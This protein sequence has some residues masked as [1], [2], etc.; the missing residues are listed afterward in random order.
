MLERFKDKERCLRLTLSVLSALFLS[1]PWLGLTPSFTL[2]F[3]FVPLLML[4]QRCAKGKHFFGWV[5]LTLSL[6]VIATQYWVGFATVWGVVASVIVQIIL[7]SLPF[8]AYNY[9]LKR[10]KK[11]LAYTLFVSLWIAMEFIY[12]HNEQ[13]SHPWIVLGNG[14][15]DSIKMI[16]WYDT[17]GVF[18]GSLW[19]LIVNVL[20]FEAIRTK[21][22][23]YRYISAIII[24][25]PIVI[26]MVIYYNHTEQ[27]S[28]VMV[29]V[30]QPNIDPYNDKFDGMSQYDQDRIIQRL[31][32]QSPGG[33][34]YILTPET[35]VSD[36]IDIDNPLRS[37]VVRSYQRL[38]E[39]R[40]PNAMLILGA[41]MY[42]FYP[43]GSER[44][45]LTARKSGD[46]YYD[47]INGS[48][49][50]SSWGVE[51]YIKSKLV[52]G[53]EK[54]P[55][56][57]FMDAISFGGLD[58]GGMSGALISQNEREVFT[59]KDST[60]NIAATICYESIYGEYMG[61]FVKNGANLLFVITNDGWWR[62]THG[63][64]HHFNYAR[65]RAIESRRAVA[66]SANTGIS[67]FINQ[68]GEVIASLDWDKRGLLHEWIKANSKI[69]F[70]V[71]Y[72]DYIGRLAMYTALVSLLYLLSYIYKKRS[73]LN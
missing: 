41:S 19:V 23:I 17:T 20:I 11:P 50:L 29:S 38:V 65:L 52:A 15:A 68:R 34:S 8:L 39:T 28:E 54:L 48:L 33:V 7:F 63:Y 64:K 59:N 25:L 32:A 22:K 46:I 42:R 2:F 35:A 40:F 73:H 26:S 10:A 60:Q 5:S 36:R 62:D 44:P 45:N 24:V 43:L 66:R 67:G 14:F 69:T 57:K 9:T 70:Y 31:I 18:G 13:I 21:S 53:V 61:K 30:I 51:S 55:Y 37:S 6:W 1:L 58:L 12:T 49:Q 72:G 27:G 56:P 4:A 3:A 71:K 16:Q 47:G